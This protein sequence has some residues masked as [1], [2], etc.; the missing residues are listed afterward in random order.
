ME[1]FLVLLPSKAETF[2]LDIS[3]VVGLVTLLLPEFH[4]CLLC[5]AIATPRRQPNS[6]ACAVVFSLLG[7]LI[8]SGWK[9]FMVELPQA[10]R[11]I[12]TIIPQKGVQLGVTFL[13]HLFAKCLNP[14]NT[15]AFTHLVRAQAGNQCLIWSG[16]LE[17][18]VETFVLVAVEVVPAVVVYHGTA[19]TRTFSMEVGQKGSSRLRDFLKGAHHEAILPRHLLCGFRQSLEMLDTTPGI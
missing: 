12:P 11:I 7:H 15:S 16:V 5:E 13:H 17:A 2:G 10:V 6:S 4:P 3:V 19:T 18:T 9:S 8:K 1:G 14:L